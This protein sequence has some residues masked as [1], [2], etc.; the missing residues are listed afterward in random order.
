MHAARRGKRSFGLLTMPPAA[1]QKLHLGKELAKDLT[2][3]TNVKQEMVVVTAD[4]LRLCLMR[5][6]HHADARRGWIAPLG[7]FVAILT[8]IF[9]AQFNDAIFSAA[10]WKSAF[11][12]GAGAS[13]LWLIRAIFFAYM[14]HKLFR[15]SDP[16]EEIVT[17]LTRE[18]ETGPGRT[19]G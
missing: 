14:A 9:S 3:C 17:R 19:D 15:Q 1:L 2:V 7:V 11:I 16:I 4:R 12:A 6:L 13:G 5:T 8:P 10:F 18:A